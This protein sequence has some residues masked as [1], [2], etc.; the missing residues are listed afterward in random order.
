MTTSTRT[1][2]IRMTGVAVADWCDNAER[3]ADFPA[4]ANPHREGGDMRERMGDHITQTIAYAGGLLG[5]DY[6]QAIADYGVAAD[7]MA[8]TADDLSA[9]IIAQFPEDF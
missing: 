2:R 8:M 9:G 3:I 1:R 4:E 5:G 6:D 7:H